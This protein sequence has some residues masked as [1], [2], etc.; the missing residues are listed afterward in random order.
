MSGGVK[1]TLSNPLLLSGSFT[2]AAR[3]QPS[4]RMFQILQIEFGKKRQNSF[5]VFGRDFRAWSCCGVYFGQGKG[6]KRRVFFLNQAG[7]GEGLPSFV[8]GME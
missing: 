8:K 5:A 7:L 3:S 2:N 1:G 6:N 4:P